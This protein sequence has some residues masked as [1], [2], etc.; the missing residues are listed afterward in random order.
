MPAPIAKRPLLPTGLR[1]LNWSLGAWTA[2][3][4]LFLYLPIAVL[5][6]Y[7]FNTSKLN[8]CI[9]QFLNNRCVL[10]NCEPRRDGCSDDT[11]DSING[12]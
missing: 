1:L 11:T 3:V 10:R 8:T 7:S 12:G 4:F 9:T 2:L 5:V 6:F